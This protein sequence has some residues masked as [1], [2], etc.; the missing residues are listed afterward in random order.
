MFI[1]KDANEKPGE[2]MKQVNKYIQVQDRKCLTAKRQ[3]SGPIE[4]RDNFFLSNFYKKAG[5]G[6]KPISSENLLFKHL[7]DKKYSNNTKLELENETDFEL[8]YDLDFG[9]VVDLIRSAG[10]IP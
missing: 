3:Y 1:A 2:V 6:F 8:N 7:S 5:V 10:L 9:T 4:N